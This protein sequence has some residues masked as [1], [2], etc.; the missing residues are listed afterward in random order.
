MSISDFCGTSGNCV[1]TSSPDALALSDELDSD[2]ASDE[3]ACELSSVLADS[4]VSALDS[5]D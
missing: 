2:D 4:E 5:E 1:V 3:D